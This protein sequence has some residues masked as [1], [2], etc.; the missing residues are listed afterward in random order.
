M[1][2]LVPLSLDLCCYFNIFS[3]QGSVSGHNSVRRQSG[4]SLLPSKTRPVK[5]EKK[6]EEEEEEKMFQEEQQRPF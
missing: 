4:Q 6:D 3:F 2:I 1:G 5:T